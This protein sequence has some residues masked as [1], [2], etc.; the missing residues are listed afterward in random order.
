MSKREY[1][2]ASLAR[3]ARSWTGII[4][5][6][7]AVT[8][9]LLG[10][11]D[12]YVIPENFFKFLIY[13]VV[14]AT[15][16]FGLIFL[17]RLKENRRYQYT[18][19]MIATVL[20]TAALELMI[21]SFGGD[22]S[23]YYG[24]ITVIIIASLGFIPFDAIW[25]IA[26]ICLVYSIY[27]FPIL[28]FTKVTHPALF[29]SDNAFLA[30]MFGTAFLWRVMSNRSTIKE[31]EMQYE[32]SEDKRRVEADRDKLRATLDIFSQVVEEVVGNERIETY[33]YRPLNNP[34]IPICWEINNCESV[35]CPAYGMKNERCWQIAG[36]RCEEDHKGQIAQKLTDCKKCEVYNRAIPDQV[37]EVR[38]M[39]NNMMHILEHTHN[40]LIEARCAAEE[41]N[42][43]KSEFLANMS[44]EIRT[45][46]NGII[47][48]TSLALNTD[49][50]DEQLD[51]LNAVQSSAYALL[52]VINDI[53]DFSKIEA[54]KMTIDTVDFNLRLTVEGVIDALAAQAAQ[55]NLELA[56]LIPYDIPSLLHGDSGKVR[57]ILLNL[58]SN[59]IKFT[60]E[61][62]VI[63]SVDLLKE[64]E[65]EATLRFS[66]S[67]TGIGIP[68]AKKEEV[69]EEFIQADGSTTRN[70][71]GTGLGL[72][73]TKRMV[74]LMGGEIGVESKQGKGSR[75]WY[76]V[77]FKKQKN[78]DTSENQ[79]PS[80]IRGMKVL[81]ADDNETNR[82]IVTKMIESF[83]CK[84]EAVASGAEAVNALKDAARL[85][86]PFNVLLLDMQ[87][88]GMDGE[89]TTTIVKNTDSIKNVVII[90]LT[91]LGNRGDVAH[92]QELGC[93][94]YLTKPIRQSFLLDTMV[95]AMSNRKAGREEG[96]YQRDTQTIGNSEPKDKLIL[97]VEDNPTN[98]KMAVTMLKKAGYQVE[99]AGNGKLAVDMVLNNYYD[100]VL[101]DVQM[102]EMDGFEATEAIR[103]SEAERRHNIIIAMTAHSLKGDR[104]RCLKAGMDDYISKP[105][106]PE[107]MFNV[108][109]KWLNL[110][111]SGCSKKSEV[112]DVQENSTER[113]SGLA[114]D[115]VD[116]KT[117]MSRFDDDMDF[118]VETVEEFLKHAVKEISTLK[119]AAKSKD[120]DVLEKSAHSIKG[121]AG[122][123]SAKRVFSI[124]RSIEDKGHDGK[125]TEAS[126]LIKELE[127]EISRL[128]DYVMALSKK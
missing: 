1:V 57:Q 101:M 80:D 40:E 119:K 11:L 30:A 76:S 77:T 43:L 8:F 53:L 64:M 34:H 35:E 122:N 92:L 62:E 44:H 96:L 120:K 87:M 4:C 7:S 2:E 32:L 110:D 48:M 33:L 82:T 127:A 93:E 16:L 58:G 65:D 50:T 61:G 9:L 47:G 105:I 111:E 123:L 91:S 94:G 23:P 3:I 49:L 6:L 81:I 41:A 99:I 39:F 29:A 59:A 79:I 112:V 24:G 37:Y 98:Q 107:E 28:I 121:A 114:E 85:G 116:L 10:I 97:L 22:V 68:E 113:E 74:E 38:E 12:Y 103:K 55:K 51:Y 88:P 42:R 19:G 18:I 20:S 54:G 78:K 69:F 108:I 86:D 46:M 117:A 75:F 66:V 15:L 60:R 73:I 72:S 5:F 26:A 71:G 124:A 128:E 83:G 106:D 56:C 27:L 84:A 90:I 21:L 63:I 17:T 31:L 36:T 13:R 115:P 125:S 52:D 25:S 95:T 70:Y 126:S 118:Y 104:E 14:T 109:K 100:L 102:P 67:D 89:H 45:P